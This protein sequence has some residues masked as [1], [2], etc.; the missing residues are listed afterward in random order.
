MFVQINTNNLNNQAKKEC[1][2]KKLDQKTLLLYLIE[3]FFHKK[4]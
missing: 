3:S 2:L 1:V 4:D